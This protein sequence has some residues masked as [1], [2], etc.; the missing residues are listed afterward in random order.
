MKLLAFALGIT[1]SAASFAQDVDCSTIKS[2]KARL[3]CFDKDVIRK[4]TAEPKPAETKV[5][6]L[7]KPP[8]KFSS[9]AWVMDESTNAMTDKKECTALYK[10][11]WTIQGTE[12]NLYVSLKGRGGVSSYTVRIDDEPA[13]S[14][15]LATQSE[16]G[17][18]TI[19]LQP[20]F[21]SL[22]NATR[23]RIQVLTLLRGIVNEDI[24]MTGFKDAVDYIRN[25]CSPENKAAN[26]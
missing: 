2:D 18:S 23:L 7:P 1:M 24:D 16:K 3:A 13:K 5:A 22:Y 12:N 17:M 14:M 4:K 6:A 9:H 11:E 20:Y 26:T 25:S 19:I 10:N 8:K 15:Q 21:E